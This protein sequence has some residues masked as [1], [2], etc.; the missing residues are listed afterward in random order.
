M[1]LAFQV[2]GFFV[3]VSLPF[4]GTQVWTSSEKAVFPAESQ[5][6][7]YAG[8]G[9]VDQTASG[10]F[11]EV[12]G[13]QHAAHI[14]ILD[15]GVRRE[16]LHVGRAVDHGLNIQPILR[17]TIKHLGI[18]HVALHHKQAVAE[19]LL[20]CVLEVVE[21]Q[22]FQALLHAAVTALAHQAVR[23]SALGFK[24]FA[25]DMDAQEAR[26]TGEK[27]ISKR[28]RLPVKESLEGIAREHLPD[29]AVIVLRQI[30]QRSR[31]R[32]RTFRA[33]HLGQS[34]RRRMRE[35]VAVCD[36][37]ALVRGGDDDAGDGQRG[38]ADFKE[39]VL[40]ADA[41]KMQHIREN[42]AEDFLGLVLGRDIFSGAGELGIREG[43]AVDLAVGRHRELIHLQV[44]IRDHIPGQA[45]A[46]HFL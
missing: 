21:Q 46:Q 15:I 2:H 10:L 33:E 8:R 41:L 13:M 43:L 1:H 11:A 29:G 37:K 20:V 4:C 16:M 3:A 24:E 25:Q 26:R 36:F 7:E 12:N 45:A 34:A 28:L 14:D 40:S 27:D 44:C 5:Y 22:G 32:R 42:P 35:H 39:I 18:G 6:A 31:C 17:Q 30:L 23:L 38:A 19:Q 9:D